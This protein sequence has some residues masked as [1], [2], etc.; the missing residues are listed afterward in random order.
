MSGIRKARKGLPVIKRVELVFHAAGNRVVDQN[1]K[2]GREIW[3][4]AVGSD[5][6]EFLIVVTVDKRTGHRID[7]SSE[8]KSGDC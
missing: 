6:C 8:I 1:G 7:E 4:A 3:I 2:E 5:Y